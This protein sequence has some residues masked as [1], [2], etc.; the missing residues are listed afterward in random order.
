MES[1]GNKRLQVYRRI[2]AAGWGVIPTV[3][4]LPDTEPEV[5]Y[6]YKNWWSGGDDDVHV[7]VGNNQL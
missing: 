5:T 6:N 4:V 3:T 1:L 7:F 2:F